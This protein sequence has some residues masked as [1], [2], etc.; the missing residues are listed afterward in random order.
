MNN[1]YVNAIE[2][3]DQTTELLV[4]GEN[5]KQFFVYKAPLLLL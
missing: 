1:I 2:A 4:K 3:S 5:L